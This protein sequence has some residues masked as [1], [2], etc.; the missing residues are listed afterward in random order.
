ML[1]E[2]KL[3]RR[4]LEYLKDP[5]LARLA[6]EMEKA[7]SVRASLIDIT[8]KCNLRCK[9]CYF[10]SEDL[11]IYK[12]PKDESE[13]DAFIEK[14]KMRGVNFWT[15][16]GGEPSLELNRLKKLYDN[17]KL[18]VVTN[19]LKKIP[20]EGFENMPIAVSVWGDHK[21][22]NELRGNNEVEVFKTALNNYRGDKRV[23]WYYT[24]MAGRANEI[25]SVTEQCIDNGNLMGY[26]FYGD[27]DGLGEACDH[28]VGFQRVYVAINKMIQKYP[29]HILN[30]SYVN[31]VICSGWLYDEKWGYDVCESITYDHEDNKERII[32]NR[33]NHYFRA[34][35]ADLKT[36]RRCCVGVK[37]DCSNCY[38]LWSHSAWVMKSTRKHLGSKQ[39]FTY[40]L[41]SCYLFY[42]VN[43]IVDFEEG[44]KMLPEIHERSSKPLIVES[45]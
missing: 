25:E 30:S 29:R 38:D 20:Y 36:T 4:I 13:F 44:I 16:V 37:R 24:T 26:N 35:N 11:D 19:G 1:K 33:Y 32:N 27:I 22:D 6:N 5:F 14:E 12:E 3:M 21:T 45:V 7:G 9:G 18:I 10:L 40:W 43:R 31:K 8:H 15:V 23:I 2:E 39:E 34:Y 42:L 28:N 17:F 41:T